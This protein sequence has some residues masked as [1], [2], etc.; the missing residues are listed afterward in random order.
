MNECKSVAFEPL[1]PEPP[2]I[3]PGEPV[4]DY[5]SVLRW[6]NDNLVTLNALLRKQRAQDVE[7]YPQP[8]DEDNHIGTTQVAAAGTVTTITWTFL[9]DYIY[10][11][12]KV[13]I[14]KML[15]ITYVWTFQ[16]IVGETTGAKV[17]TGNDHDFNGKLVKAAG[18][19]TLT[20]VITNSGTSDQTLDIVIQSWARR[21]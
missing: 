7:L 5:S 2:R 15:N 14:D 11:F 20:L 19:T 21:K 6:I 9:K 18:D 17:L 4:P 3:P 12:K 1:T 10:Y 16:N 8:G 13:Y